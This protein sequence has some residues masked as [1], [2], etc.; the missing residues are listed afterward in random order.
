VADVVLDNSG[1]PADLDRQVDELWSE[2]EHRL[3]GKDR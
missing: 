1:E 2:L 3:G